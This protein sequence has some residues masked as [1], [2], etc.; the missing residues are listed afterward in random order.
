MISMDEDGRED[1]GNRRGR[2]KEQPNGRARELTKQ[3]CR[4]GEHRVLQD[5]ED[6]GAP[7]AMIFRVRK[8]TVKPQ[9]T[10]K[11]MHVGSYN[12]TLKKKKKKTPSCFN[13]F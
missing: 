8:I 11:Q 3:A 4:R 6:R 2:E 7:F 13:R 1:E 10:E 5:T 12:K 9:L